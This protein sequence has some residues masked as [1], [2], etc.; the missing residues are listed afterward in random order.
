MLENSGTIRL[1]DSVAGG[2]TDQ[3]G[4]FGSGVLHNTGTIEKIGGA[5]EG[6]V[7]GVLDNDGTVRVTAGLLR[8]ESDETVQQSGTFTST[9]SATYV[10]DSGV[11]VLASGAVL[12]GRPEIGDGD[13]RIPEGMTVDVPSG[14]T[15]RQNGGT[16]SGDG[17]LRV[18]GTL[19]WLQGDH[20]GGGTTLIETG[21]TATLQPADPTD[22]A[23][24][25]IA[26][27]RA[28]INR[29]TFNVTDATL[30]AFDGGSITNRGTMVLG[31]DAALDGSGFG[32]GF[33]SLL[34][35]V[36]TLRK[37]GATT[38]S[39]DIPI[40]NDGTIDVQGGKL[41]ATQ[42]QNFTSDFFFGGPR[43]AIVG[44]TYL[45]KGKLGVPQGV[46][47]I[48]GRI[49]LDGA[50][51]GLEER[52]FPDPTDA[53]ASLHRIAG[54]G[55]LVLANGKSVSSGDGTGTFSNAGILDL[56]AG[57]TF[58]AAE[59]FAQV[60][61][62]VLRTR[63]PSSGAPGKLAVTGDAALGGRLDVV[64]PAHPAT[65]TESPIVTYGSHSV[66]FPLRTGLSGF[67]LRFD[68]GALVLRSQPTFVARQ[69]AAPPVVSEPET[70]AAPEQDATAPQQLAAAALT[71]RGP[72]AR[73]G[74]YLVAT[75]RGAK[76]IR[77]AVS[78]RG[79]DI[80]ALTGPRAG[81][82]RVTWAGRS[83][84]VSL[85]SS[86]PD[87][88]TLRVFRGAARTG[89]VVVRTRSARRVAIAAI[90]VR[91]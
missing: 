33:S 59:G 41:D 68:P 70:P 80:V 6:D 13:L 23:F 87:R 82:V 21:G 88:R 83:R 72:W 60:A 91:R 7:R 30:E 73:R 63:V 52:G 46:E 28:L 47:V 66:D 45:L 77:R 1:D 42:L 15:L 11:F 78:G 12:G 43:G 29:G 3:T 40:D 10:L 85:R 36:G 64:S 20:R 19:T 44:G 9:G 2:C 22:H 71:V 62:G 69:N 38:I 50:D 84:T 16:V 75:R 18:L 65:G 32:D 31:G 55:E 8:L 79:L 26:D 17:T 5:G 27:S 57:T 67:V 58:N 34:H 24:A 25:S 37:T 74:A 48:A 90:L 76:L 14:A 4:I 61:G 35:N 53:L 86:R 39:A 81:S 89:T 54:G 49:V 51:A 56:G